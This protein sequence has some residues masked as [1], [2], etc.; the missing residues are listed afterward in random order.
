MALEYY[1]S[2]TIWSTAGFQE[3]NKTDGIGVCNL[4]GNYFVVEI[5]EY[6]TRKSR[7]IIL[8]D[9]GDSPM[10]CLFRLAVLGCLTAVNDRV[11]VTPLKYPDRMSSMWPLTR[12]DRR[13]ASRMLFLAICSAAGTYL[14]TV[15]N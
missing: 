2:N 11:M 9:R 3:D 5:K 12:I 8:A 4:G 14:Y 7:G 13:P 10:H 6:L 15:F 1:T